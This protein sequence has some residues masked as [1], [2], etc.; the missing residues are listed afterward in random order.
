[1]CIE[2]CSCSTSRI[3][4]LCRLKGRLTTSLL[5]FSNQTSD[6]LER[7]RGDRRALEFDAL[8]SSRK[9]GTFALLQGCRITSLSLVSPGEPEK[10]LKEVSNGRKEIEK[11][12]KNKLTMT[13]LT[14]PHASRPQPPP[15]L[16]PHL[17]SAFSIPA[18]QSI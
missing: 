13:P 7:N 11:E 10:R 18:N 4:F 3:Q 12:W 16:P 14:F 1:M 5:H 2:I 17:S 9:L 15:Q 8:M 6:M